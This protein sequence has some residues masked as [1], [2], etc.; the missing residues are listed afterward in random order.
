MPTSGST[1]ARRERK[2]LEL[3]ASAA[4]AK[5]KFAALGSSSRKRIIRQFGM[6][7]VAGDVGGSTADAESDVSVFGGWWTAL[8]RTWSDAGDYVDESILAVANKLDRVHSAIA[9]EAR[10]VAAGAAGVGVRL[11][12]V[13][14]FVI[15][16]VRLASEG[17]G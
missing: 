1:A 17:R 11:L 8:E 12:A 5:K 2:R 15:I 13:A 4:S 6:A 10:R 14:V 7:S 16:A 3:R 9:E